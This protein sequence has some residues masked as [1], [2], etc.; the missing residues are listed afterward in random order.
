MLTCVDLR[1]DEWGIGKQSRR[2]Q[3]SVRKVLSELKPQALLAL[4]D[5]RLEVT[6]VPDDG[7]SVW[8]YFPIHVKNYTH[9]CMGP[10]YRLLIAREV[11]RESKPRTRVLLVFSA[12]G[13]AGE[14]AEMFEDYL[15]DHLGHALL[16]LR[17]PKAPNDCPDAQREWRM[18]IEP[19]GA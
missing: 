19:K 16:Y 8:A 11:L 2:F 9:L 7:L 15:R 18:S 17:S 13:F 4:K 5:S 14:P 3:S 12:A 1:M 6:V 10:D